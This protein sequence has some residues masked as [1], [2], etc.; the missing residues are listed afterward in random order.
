MHSLRQPTPMQ[1]P[2]MPMHFAHGGVKPSATP[3]S[4]PHGAPGTSIFVEQLLMHSPPWTV[5]TQ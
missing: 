5:F 4:T 1:Y 3:Q 2:S